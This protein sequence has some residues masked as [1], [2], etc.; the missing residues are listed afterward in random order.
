MNSEV[1]RLK[2]KPIEP[3]PEFTAK[4]HHTLGLGKERLDDKTQSIVDSFSVVTQMIG[5][6]TEQISTVNDNMLVI[7]EEAERARAEALEAKTI[8]TNALDKIN[9]IKQKPLRFIV[10]WVGILINLA[11]GGFLLAL[12]EKW[13]NK[14]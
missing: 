9:N 6:A 10:R 12:F 4:E 5:H 11:L 2:I 13:V 7:L 14:K 3:M 1:I 8:A